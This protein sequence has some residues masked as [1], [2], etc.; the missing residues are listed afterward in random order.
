MDFQNIILT[1]QR[2]WSEQGCLLLQP[3]DMEVGA[4]TS[5]PATAIFAMQKPVW[6]TAYVQPC[7]RPTDGRF[8]EN[9]NRMQHYFQFQVIMKPYPKG[10]QDIYLKSLEALGI[11]V[12]KNDIRFV[13]DN[14]ENPTIGASGL[15][16]EVWMNG[17]EITQFTYMQQI[18][19]IEISPLPIE[20]T[21]GLERIATDLQCIDN[22]WNIK[23]NSA[24]VLSRDVLLEFEKQHCAYNFYHADINIIK[25]HFEDY[26]SEAER[27]SSIKILYPAYEFCLKASHAFNVLESRGLLS[28]TERAGYIAKVRHATKQCLSQ[29]FG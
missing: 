22:I 21:Y 13:E 12:R 3:Y 24:G 4:G 1:L 28:V 29:Q 14:W 9:P 2:F 10:I 20:I 25:R 18:G 26:I 11:E 17:A 5:H 6:N 16:W 23:W 8:G 7:R 15:G 19:G 27:L